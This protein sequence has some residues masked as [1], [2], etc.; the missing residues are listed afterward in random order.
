MRAARGRQWICG[1]VA[2]TTGVAAARGFLE[3]FH[4]LFRD[5]VGIGVAGGLDAENV[6]ELAP[7]LR[8]WP[9]LSLDAEG[10][11]READDTLGAKARIF[12]LN[13]FDVIPSD[14]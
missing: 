11:L 9:D 2:V 13:A 10:R 6:R 5:Q 1:R 12:A 3:T 14:L 4:G 8:D 7:L